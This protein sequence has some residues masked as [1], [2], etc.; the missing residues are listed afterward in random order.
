MIENTCQ[1]TRDASSVYNLN[2]KDAVFKVNVI[3][4][5]IATPTIRPVGRQLIDSGVLS[6]GVSSLSSRSPDT[7]GRKVYNVI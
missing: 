7:Q 1:Y 6:H 2:V 4:T 5:D 3:S